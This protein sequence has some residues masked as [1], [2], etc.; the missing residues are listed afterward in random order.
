MPDRPR[1]AVSVDGGDWPPEATLR[2]LAESAIE[3]AS[4][5]AAAGTGRLAQQV[6]DRPESANNLEVSILFTD[7]A[8]IRR[9]NAQY[10]GKDSVTNVLSF[11]QPPGALLGDVVLAA[12]SLRREAALAGKS[13]EDHIAHLVVHGFLHLL[14]YDH[15][16]DADADKMEE[17]ERVALKRLGI[18]DPYARPQEP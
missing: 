11:P 1:V 17:L 18:S 15:E 4:G 9:L 8:A 6:S 13:I 12:E 10:R 2:R 7:D 3:A 14:G 5:S 16:V